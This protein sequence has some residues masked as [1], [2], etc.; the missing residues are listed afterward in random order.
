MLQKAIGN[1]VL[2]SSKRCSPAPRR[3][4]SRPTPANHV[5]TPKKLTIWVIK[6]LVTGLCPYQR[7]SGP[8]KPSKYKKTRKQLRKFSGIINFYRDMCQ[9]HSELLSP[10][11]DLTPK[12]VKY[13]WKD[14]HQNCFDAI[15]RVIGRDVLLAYL[16][17]ND[18]FEIHTDASNLKVGAFIPQKGNPIAFYSR[19]MN[20]AI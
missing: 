18:P 6:S 10:L 5:F 19:K 16:E 17:S 3:M 15:K 8:F 2:L 4:G 13:D 11:T 20:S 14:E 1:N 12:N 9:N 7:K